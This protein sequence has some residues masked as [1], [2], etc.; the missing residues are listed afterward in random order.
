MVATMTIVECQL[1]IWSG[2]GINLL[3]YQ[4]EETASRFDLTRQPQI[5]SRNLPFPHAIVIVYFVVSRL[6]RCESL[7][8]E[9]KTR[10][11]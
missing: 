9:T 1:G 2:I 5:E 4:I 8:F 10:M 3:S 11:A 6:I 7:Q